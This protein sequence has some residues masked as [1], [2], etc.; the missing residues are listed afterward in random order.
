[1]GNTTLSQAKKS[2]NDEFYTRLTD[3]EKELVHYRHHFK[4]KVVLCNCD[5]PFES[6]FFKYFVLNF[7]VLGLK[8]LVTTCYGTSSIAN[9]Q[10]S[11]FEIS[12]DERQK[13]RPYK[14][15]VNK[16]CDTTGDGGIDMTDVINLFKMRENELIELKGDGDF[17]SDECIE[18]L[19]EAD[20]VVTN[21]PFSLFR[22]YVAK[23][24]E[25]DKKFVIIGNQ[26]AL[27]YKE[28]FPLL[29]DGEMWLGNNH[30]APKLFYVPSMLEER[31]N[32]TKD[33]NGKLVASFGNICWFTNLDIKKRHE[34]I[35]LVKKYNKEDYP[36]YDNYDAI[37]VDK[38]KDIPCDYSGVMGVPITFMD[39]YNPDQFEIVGNADANVL[40]DDWKGA[41]KTIVADYYKQGNKGQIQEGW[42]NP[43]YYNLKGRV[44]AP[45]KRLLVRNKKTEIR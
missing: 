31:K 25:H 18:A 30:P 9:E 5:D 28:I 17:R 36:K 27:T 29:Q 40:P 32:I 41:S 19:K 15:I 43:I 26:N 35:I 23:L 3:I 21:P 20:I 16:V 44:I 42:R 8:K 24:I 2:K 7:N 39:K 13:G 12:G 10:I 37:N 45:Y 38:V 22:D 33:E 14:A 6:N 1:M 11:L 34:D 4:D